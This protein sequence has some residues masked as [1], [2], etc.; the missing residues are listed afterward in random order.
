MAVDDLKDYV[1]LE[2]EVGDTRIQL[3][4]VECMLKEKLPNSER[5]KLEAHHSCMLYH[6]EM[7]NVKLQALSKKVKNGIRGK[8]KEDLK[9]L[10]KDARYE[11]EVA[12][13]VRSWMKKD[14]AAAEGIRSENLSQ[15]LGR[16]A[17]E[18]VDEENMINLRF[19]LPDGS[20]CCHRFLM[21]DSLQS[22][23]SYLDVGREVRPGTYRLVI[24]YP[25]RLVFSDSESALVLSDLGLA[26]RREVLLFLE[27]I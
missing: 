22:V 15:E 24:P 25:T 10:L 20:R 9:S 23:F 1:A 4:N 13:H 3:A 19:R 14:Y 8:T 27:S 16:L 2:S 26:G 11:L 12:S 17:S 21:S 7:L 5:N 18:E 6:L